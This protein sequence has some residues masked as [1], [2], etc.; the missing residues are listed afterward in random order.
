MAGVLGGR[1]D[2]YLKQGGRHPETGEQ[3]PRSQADGE[4]RAGE[5]GRGR[6][7]ENGRM[8]EKR[9]KVRRDWGGGGG[10]AALCL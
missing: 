6:G 4:S 8:R 1:G 10:G 7:S 5:R 9:S 3:V 2:S